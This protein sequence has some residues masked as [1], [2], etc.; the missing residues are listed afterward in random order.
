MAAV[1]PGILSRTP[2]AAR[3][4]PKTV[5][6]FEKKKKAPEIPIKLD[7]SETSDEFSDGILDSGNVRF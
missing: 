7:A 6:E 3:I 5:E 4:F 2:P 1:L